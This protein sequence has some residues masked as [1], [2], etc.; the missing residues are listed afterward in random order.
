MAKIDIKQH[1][2]DT[3]ISE[4]EKGTPPWR[5]PWTGDTTGAALPLRHDGIAYRGVNVLMLWA[6]SHTKGYASARWMTYRQALALGAC[7]RKGEKATRSVFYGTFE[8]EIDGE[9]EPQ[10][11]R[12]AKC[13]NV[14]N[15]DQIEGLPEDYYVRPAPPRHLGTEPV[16]ELDAFFAATGAT[17]ITSE[18]PRAYYAPGPDHIHMPPIGTFFDASGYYGTLGHETVHWTGSATR[19]DRIKRFEDHAEH[20]F[21]ELVAE[22]GACFLAVQLG[23]A[24]AF[25]QSAAY[26]EGWL[27]AL[28][29]DKGLI[30]KAA[31]EAQKAVDFINAEVER[32]GQAA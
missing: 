29:S 7:V 32:Y 31:A 1:V 3:I 27:Q 6:T 30:F 28:R 8:K 5:K 17:I 14:F 2:T 12:Y 13:N 15:A 24:P 23:V 21:E 25:D 26:I 9:N 20:A 10:T 22:I 16:T 4:M 19:L 11:S 18:T